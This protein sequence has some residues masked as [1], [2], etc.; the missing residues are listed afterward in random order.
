MATKK[1]YLRK[2]QKLQGTIKVYAFSINVYDF[3]G[4]MVNVS[5]CRKEGEEYEL[6]DFYSHSTK[7]DN[8]RIYQKL[9]EF[10]KD[11][12]TF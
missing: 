9:L 1:G 12:K 4:M 11:C 5:I 7:E 2:I 3:D 6:F 8:E 10:I